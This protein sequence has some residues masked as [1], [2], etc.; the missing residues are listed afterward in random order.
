MIPASVP[1]PKMI[2]P[3][4]NFFSLGCFL[5][6]V[7]GIVE[8]LFFP[9]FGSIGSFSGVKYFSKSVAYGNFLC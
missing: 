2:F 5:S 8:N 7:N 3:V 6:D 4:L 1:T 9:K